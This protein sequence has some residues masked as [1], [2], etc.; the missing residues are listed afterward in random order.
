MIPLDA[1]LQPGDT[2]PEEEM[3]RENEIMKIKLQAEFGAVFG[4]TEKELPPDIEHE[5]LN[6]VYQFEKA[7]E[8]QEMRSVA[9]LLK[10]P[11]FIPFEK[12][13]AEEQENTWQSVMDLYEQSNISI[14][15][16]HDYPL[17]VRYRFVTEELPM[18]RT[19]FV[20]MPDMVL[21]FTYE[22]FH[23]NIAAD[24]EDLVNRFLHAWL[25]KDAETCVA[26]LSDRVV[27]E[28][29]ELMSPEEVSSRFRMI[30]D[31]FKS[32]EEGAFSITETSYDK[33]ETAD[34]DTEY[35]LGY[36]E[37][38]VQWNAILDNAEVLTIKG[39]FKLYL[40]SKFGAWSIMYFVMPGWKWTNE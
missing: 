36:A 26:C 19:V 15:F 3:R 14:D 39:A 34:K 13:A 10:K 24:M 30:F 9:D 35:M 29:C 38:E 12:L 18:H 27:L 6:N 40:E 22:E 16:L 17:E 4:E 2:D 21:G 25:E 7:W 23:P 37:G 32:F 11:L 33:Q 5:F 1:P 8:K 28:T 20:N 31:C